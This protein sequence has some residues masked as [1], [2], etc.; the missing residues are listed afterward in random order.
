M[1]DHLVPR[2]AGM[3]VLSA[4]DGNALARYCQLWSRWRKAEAFLR[5]HGEVYPLKD[6]AGKVKYLQPFP[7]VSIAA[8]LAQQLTKLEQEFGLTPSARTRIQAL[9]SA[10]PQERPSAKSRFFESA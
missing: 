1:W 2:L 6:E 10:A 7:Q 4:I 5:K 8:N 9:Q 3:G